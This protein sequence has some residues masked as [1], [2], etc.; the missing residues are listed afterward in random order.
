MLVEHRPYGS[1]GVVELLI[2][3]AEH[4]LDLAVRIAIPTLHAA[5]HR[6]EEEQP[7][8]RRCNTSEHWWRNAPSALG[9]PEREGCATPGLDSR[10]SMR[11]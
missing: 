6:V 2:D 3:D 1:V 11:H 8:Y 4:R 5:P 7:V 9:A 10:Q